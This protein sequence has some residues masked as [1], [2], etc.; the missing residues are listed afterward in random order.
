MKSKIRVIIALLLVVALAVPV[1]SPTP[2]L[3]AATPV[4]V[5]H[6]LQTYSSD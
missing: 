1:L 2:A 6:T 4:Y 3:A 5:D